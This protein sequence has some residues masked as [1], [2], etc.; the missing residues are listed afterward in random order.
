MIGTS[1]ADENAFFEVCPTLEVSWLEAPCE[2]PSKL[3]G[4]RN[5]ESVVFDEPGTSMNWR[6]STLFRVV[7]KELKRRKVF[8][9]ALVYAIMAWG[10]MQVGELL[11]E[12]LQ[13]PEG[14]YT[15]LVILVLLGFPVAVVLAWAYEITP[16]G[17]R[18]DL[19]RELSQDQ[20]KNVAPGRLNWNWGEVRGRIAILPLCDMARDHDLSHFCE[21]LA[22]E[23]QNS[24][25]TVPGL[26]VIARAHSSRYGGRKI[27]IRR[28][29]REL[30]ANAI[31]EGS[32]RRTNAT[33]RISI[34]LV[35]VYTGI[36]IW[37][38]SH[39]VALENEFEIQKRVADAV[40]I[41]TRKTFETANYLQISDRQMNL[42]DF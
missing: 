23:I 21:G 20:T 3:F 26:E 42:A 36:D 34:Q 33:Y 37:A 22:E 15:L 12:A 38:H 6:D 14:A 30:G 28:I 41:D 39:D 10:V 24:L 31:I 18:R 40:A 7:L 25:C 19:V 35:D 11:F 13:V 1:L 2:T 17:V 5:T 8:Q 32:V 27:N 29:R 16:D 4:K 9:V